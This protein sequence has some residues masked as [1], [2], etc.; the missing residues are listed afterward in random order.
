M[1]LLQYKNIKDIN[2]KPKQY[3]GARYNEL[4]NQ[5]LPAINI[6]SNFGEN[7]FDVLEIH[8]YDDTNNY[9][10]SNHKTLN[11][12]ISN[13]SPNFEN[14]PTIILNPQKDLLDLNLSNA[15]Y[16]IV[17]NLMRDILGSYNSVDNYLY[18]ENIST[19]R[20]EL[21]VYPVIKNDKNYND[22]IIRFANI[23]KDLYSYWPDI[24][25][26]FSKN[27]IV[28]VI[29][30]Q[31]DDLSTP[32][33]PYSLLL[34]LYE[35][36]P[37]T[38]K[39][40]DLF[41]ISTEVSNPIIDYVELKAPIILP[42]SNLVNLKSPNFNLDLVQKVGYDTDY[43]SWN[44]VLGTN[45]LSSQQIINMY[46]N[47]ISGS[48]GGIILNV[49]Y[50]DY[51]N[52]VNFS[53]ATERLNNFKYKLELIEYYNLVIQ[54]S[55]FLIGTSSAAI[56][57]TLTQSLNRINQIISSFDG[58]E[59][60]LY[61]ES[62]SSYITTNGAVVNRTWPK[63][64]STKPYILYPTTSSI[65]ETWFENEIT[66]ALAY[67]RN[68]KNN[69]VESI[70]M[71]IRDQQDE[72]GNYINASYMLFV[73]MIAHH[74]DILWLYINNLTEAYNKE[75]KLT[76][77]IAKDLIYHFVESFGWDLDD[78]ITID[79]LWETALGIDAAGNYITGSNGL[80][81]I[82]PQ[83][84]QKEIWKRIYNNLPNLLKQKG[85]ARGIKALISCYG[86]PS[87]ILRI[88]EYG[89][90]TYN[91]SEYEIDKYT[92]SLIFS[93]NQ[94]I[95]VPSVSDTKTI[96]FRFNPYSGS[97]T[98]ITQSLLS[99]DRF[100][101]SL[102][103]SGSI[104]GRLLYNQTAST[105]LPIFDGNYWNIMMT[106]GSDTTIYAYRFNNDRITYK[107]SGSFV[108]PIGTG[109]FKIGSG[110]NGIN[111]YTG[112]L[113]EFRIWNNILSEY[114]FEAYCKNS[115]AYFTQNPTASY[116]ALKIR[117]TFTDP[118]LYEG[119]SNTLIYDYNPTEIVNYGT[120][121]IALTTASFS[122]FIETRHI[123]TPKYW[124]NKI[125]SN[126]VR[127]ESG[128]LLGNLDFKKKN[129]YINQTKT[130]DS[131]KLGINFSP[132]DMINEDIF[133]QMGDFVLDNYI[134]NP[135]DQFKSSYTSLDKLKEFYFKKYP[136]PNN[137]YDYIKYI[138]IY[139]NSL[140]KQIKKLLPERNNAI[141]GLSYES[142]ILERPKYQWKPLSIT[143][144]S[145]QDTI[146]YNLI[147]TANIIGY[148]ATNNE[149][150]SLFSINSQNI[151]IEATNNE[152]FTLFE[153][154]GNEI[155]I[156]TQIENNKKI[157]IV[158]SNYININSNI[159][160]QDY[161]LYGLPFTTLYK[162]LDLYSY[163]SSSAGF[164]TI[165]YNSRKSQ[166]STK[167]E[168]F[169]ENK[170]LYSLYVD[171]K[172]EY[173]NPLNAILKGTFIAINTSAPTQFVLNSSFDAKNIKRFFINATD[174]YKDREKMFLNYLNMLSDSSIKRYISI[175]K[176]IQD[177]IVNKLDNKSTALYEIIGPATMSYVSNYVGY[178]IVNYTS[179]S[180]T[181]DSDFYG[182]DISLEF[183]PGDVCDIAYYNGNYILNGDNYIVSKSYNYSS[184]IIEFNKP[185][186]IGTF[187]SDVSYPPLL[188]NKVNYAGRSYS[189]NMDTRTIT[190]TYS[191]MIIEIPVNFI[192]YYGNSFLFPGFD[193]GS[194]NYELYFYS[195]KTTKS[196]IFF[197]YYDNK[198][199]KG[200]LNT[201]ETTIDGKEPVEVYKSIY[202]IDTKVGDKLDN[203]TD[204]IEYV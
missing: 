29:N 56:Q 131:P 79:G 198:K 204:E 4:L 34:K 69:L 125:N 97:L 121:S 157:F 41:W 44:D 82:T 113:Q 191:N 146:N 156:E 84:R 38:I 48:V 102:Y 123:K 180:V 181:L 182:N 201:R 46:L 3:Y 88:K 190:D 2:S 92:Y 96:Q 110:S 126:K 118:K 47:N 39:E 196:E 15:R 148:G 80:E 153:T 179:N 9:I 6:F 197:N 169:N 52:F 194:S 144:E 177:S 147:S 27:V 193:Y 184:N 203:Y 176:I 62:G 130:F 145:K 119:A 149:Y 95:S 155:S 19:D 70:P 200:F 103:S 42:P 127:I 60:Y 101:L 202:S 81:Y 160:K 188:V 154:Q 72:T 135:A 55:S 14:K 129:E 109:S 24:V 163:F 158:D 186:S 165:I 12:S 21:R 161:S 185:I 141:V 132:I 89:G 115:D 78:G 32:E 22:R 74:Y 1:S 105:D 45:P 195:E 167:T 187:N 189:A 85:T 199:Y 171:T 120:S 54:S 99:S 73:N 25:M 94:Y 49:D 133:A 166:F 11:F 68:N 87:T 31:L 77:G 67:D 20:T 136:K 43:K 143:S 35:P 162:K 140:F 37:A 137:V 28:P 26:N 174:L 107:W 139:D 151:G 40:K 93:G 18:I 116:N 164:G 183:Q 66:A 76:Q 13:L 150:L 128:S 53:S 175:N 117:Y 10:K 122:S 98:P 114:E 100:N 17:Y 159:N 86:V 61:Y 124:G 142:H 106:S 170:F 8:V 104:Y 23:R 64:N 90:T 138:K 108:S 58:F 7:N 111:N 134:G 75:Q 83:D 152:Y 63:Q 192:T 172:N 173:Y 5:E 36:L 30:W 168:K 91:N 51:N 59:N 71:H 178:Q 57:N 65:A 16:K 112:S 50:S 33:Y